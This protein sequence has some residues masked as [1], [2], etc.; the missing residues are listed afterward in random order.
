[1]Y[2]RDFKTTFFYIKNTSLQ[3][4]SLAWS[5]TGLQEEIGNHL[6]HSCHETDSLL[7]GLWQ[8]L[9]SFKKGVY[10]FLFYRQTRFQVMCYFY[11]S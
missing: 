6:F 5:S 2:L 7:K 1:M 4:F 8:Y 11:Q 9:F 10:E 3:Y